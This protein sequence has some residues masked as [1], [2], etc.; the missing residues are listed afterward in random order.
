M[1]S[2]E[3]EVRNHI[4]GA[5]DAEWVVIDDGFFGCANVK[6]KAYVSAPGNHGHLW[7]KIDLVPAFTGGP[8]LFGKIS[9]AV[10][11]R[12]APGF[13]FCGILYAPADGLGPGARPAGHIYEADERPDYRI[14]GGLMIIRARIFNRR[15]GLCFDSDPLSVGNM[16]TPMTK[17]GPYAAAERLVEN[18]HGEMDAFVAAVRAAR[19][20]DLR[21]KIIYFMLGRKKSSIGN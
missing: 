7:K 16:G 8:E 17:I 12:L 21:R 3:K 19:A 14:D 5:D 15:R 18:K 1:W 20:G 9:A 4:I 11:C 10:G 6:I 13:R 2:D